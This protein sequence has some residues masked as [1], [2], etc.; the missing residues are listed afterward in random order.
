M[1][2]PFTGFVI[3]FNVST[4]IHR[5]IQ[6]ESMC[7]VVVVEDCEGGEL[8]LQEPGL[9]VNLKCG[10]FIVFR[11]VHFTHFNLHF[12][13]RRISIVFHSDVHFKSW[14]E[15]RNG[16]GDNKHFSSS[17]TDWSDSS[18]RCPVP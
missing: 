2:P 13:G 18:S 4:G 8:C 10:D 3:N 1:V 12:V 16:W 5:D 11:S 14:V 15:N 7:L 17:Y 9:V 6:D